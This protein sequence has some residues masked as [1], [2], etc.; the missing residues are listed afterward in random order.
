MINSENFIFQVNLVTSS[1]LTLFEG[2]E[3]FPIQLWNRARSASMD[4]LALLSFVSLQEAHTVMQEIF[5]I[6]CGE[7]V[8][9]DFSVAP[10]Q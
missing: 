4:F 1:L 9:Y 5:M 2:S 3:S 6:T 10:K 7:S 8:E